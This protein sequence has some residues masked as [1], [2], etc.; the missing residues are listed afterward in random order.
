[1]EQKNGKDCRNERKKLTAQE[2]RVISLEQL[3]ARAKTGSKD[4]GRG[5]KRRKKNFLPIG[6]AIYTLC[7]EK[8]FDISDPDKLMRWVEAYFE[9][10]LAAESRSNLFLTT[11][12][13]AT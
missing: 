13:K 11:K 10:G 9:F 7:V 6:R 12:S 5:S 2:K 3:K 1:M 8:K 4:L